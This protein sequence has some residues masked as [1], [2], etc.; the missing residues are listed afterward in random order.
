MVKRRDNTSKKSHDHSPKT[1]AIFRQKFLTPLAE[2]N[3]ASSPEKS[4]KRPHKIRVVLEEK[5]DQPFLSPK[6]R[7]AVR[8]KIG[9][10]L[11]EKTLFF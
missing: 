2:K 7:V 11:S 10:I 1:Q 5:N 8:R 9:A 4:H 6:T 3:A